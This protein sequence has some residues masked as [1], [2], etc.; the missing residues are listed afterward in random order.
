MTSHPL[1]LIGAPSLIEVIIAGLRLPSQD[2]K[3]AGI[4]TRRMCALVQPAP[5]IECIEHLKLTLIA[6]RSQ[7]G[8]YLNKKELDKG[9]ASQIGNYCHHT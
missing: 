9:E 7:M 5:V 2:I 8:G 1:P 3:E 6:Q 4:P